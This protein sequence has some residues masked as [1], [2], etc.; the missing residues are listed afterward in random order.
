MK[1]VKELNNMKVP[2]VQID[3][4]LEKYKR[5]PIFQ[6]KLDLANEMLLTFGPPK[7]LANKSNM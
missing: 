5:M 1:T 4:S 2:I 7:I 3:N 6:E